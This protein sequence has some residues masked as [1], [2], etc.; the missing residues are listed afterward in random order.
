MPTEDK[1]AMP[2]ARGIRRASETVCSIAS[3]DRGQHVLSYVGD[4]SFMD[5]T[6]QLG[7]RE[8]PSTRMLSG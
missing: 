8:I 6:Q 3:L 2:A 7:H 4:T 1:C 5:V